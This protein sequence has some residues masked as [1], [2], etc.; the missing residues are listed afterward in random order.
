MAEK[1]GRND[2]CPCGSGRKYK[3]CCL[4]VVEAARRESLLSAEDLSTTSDDWYDDVGEL[5]PLVADDIVSVGYASGMVKS[6]K[7]ALA[8]DGLVTVE[9]HAP[10]I[11]PAILDAIEVEDAGAFEGAWGDPE[12]ARPIQVEIIDIETADDD[13]ITI[14]VY[15]RGPLLL[16]QN[17]EETRSLHRLCE[18]MR[19]APA[20]RTIDVPFPNEPLDDE[21]EPDSLPLPP[22]PQPGTCALCGVV[23]LP[24]ASAAHLAACAPA[25]DARGGAR[26]DLLHLR[27][28]APGLPWYWL[29]VDIRASA[30]LQTLDRFLRDT[31][32]ECCGHLSQFIIGHVDYVQ[33]TSGDLGWGDGFKRRPQRRMTARVGDAMPDIGGHVQYEY[34]FGSTTTLDIE[35]VGRRQGTPGRTVT[36]LLAQNTRVPWKCAS[37]DAPATQVC[38]FCTDDLASALV[39]ARHAR[40]RHTRGETESFLP[41]VNSPRMGVCGYTGE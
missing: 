38:V 36:R 2:P 9:W 7:R 4:E 28:T 12:A 30:T 26:H 25:H 24:D 17:T 13:I 1:T 34:D 29:D 8:G 14:E 31:W 20:G 40:G 33:V 5:E 41:V 19:T 21:D 37:C 32:L 16:F 35:I 18:A 39:C 22:I 6:L 3:K 15:N 10:S 11:P 23:L 27:V